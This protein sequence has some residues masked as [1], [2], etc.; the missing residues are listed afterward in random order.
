M[1]GYVGE[2]EVTHSR[3]AEVRVVSNRIITAG[4]GAD[5]SG[6][7]FHGEESIGEIREVSAL[8]SATYGMYLVLLVDRLRREEAFMRYDAE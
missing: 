1:L 6:G 5:F 2:E 8:L 3:E 7:A 4:C